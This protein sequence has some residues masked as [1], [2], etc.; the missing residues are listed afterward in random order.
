MIRLT[1]I[2][3]LIVA[4]A[5][6]KHVKKVR[7]TQDVEEN[8]WTESHPFV[9]CSLLAPSPNAYP[10][11]RELIQTRNMT[12]SKRVLLAE[13]NLESLCSEARANLHCM[14][15]ALE[16]ASVKCKKVFK[17]QKLTEELFHKAGSFLNDIC[18]DEVLEAIRR[19]LDCVW[20][21]E[22]YSKVNKCRFPNIEKDCTKLRTYSELS[23][24]I[25]EKYRPNCDGDDVVSCAS[26][27]VAEDCHDEEAVQLVE[28]IGNS[29]FDKFPVAPACPDNRHLKSLLKFFK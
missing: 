1:L 24:C 3:V 6:A 23:P 2:I 4:A 27:A 26:E 9:Q 16:S 8:C 15:N 22:V 20:D 28:L 25:G 10:V 11:L 12:E 18:D 7:R 19:N 13:G 21:V 5:S 14:S 29:Y 17:D